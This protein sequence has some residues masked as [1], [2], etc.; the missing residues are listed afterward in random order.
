VAIVGAPS[1]FT[2]LEGLPSGVRIISK[3]ETQTDLALWFIETKEQLVEELDTIAVVAKTAP[4]WIAWPKGGSA[5]LGDLTQQVVRT[6]AMNAGLVD[7]KIASINRKWSGLLF[8][9]RGNPGS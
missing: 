3:P 1:D 5:K 2:T 6:L 4:V 9:W 8:T 7:Y